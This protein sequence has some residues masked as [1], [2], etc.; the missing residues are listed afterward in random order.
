V[1]NREQLNRIELMQREML[2]LLKKIFEE[3]EEFE[4]EPKIALS[5]TGGLMPKSIGQGVKSLFT[6]TEWDGPAGTGNKVK[7]SGPIVFASDNEAVATVDNAGQ[8]L[9]ADG[10]SIDVDVISD[11]QVGVA[12]ITGV[13]P[14]STNKVAAGDVLTVTGSTGGG[15]AVSA[16]GVLS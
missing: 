16:T 11:M 10:F 7:T 6:F 3:F 15:V 9:N 13:D 4:D 5:A 12:N 14:A 2:R 1:F 8:R